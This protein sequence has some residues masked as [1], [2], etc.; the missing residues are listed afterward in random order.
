MTAILRSLH[1]ALLVSDL[2]KAE[3]F[4]GQVLGLEQAPRSLNFPGLW[5][6]VGDF[7]LHLIHHAGWQAP[8]PRPD[9]W[10]RNAHIALQV[11]DLAVIKTQLTE[12]GY[13]L[14]MSSS[15]RAALFTQDADGNVVELSQA[16]LPKSS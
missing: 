5:Y 15:G 1:V 8:C 6:Q 10:G 2:K 11:N 13:P 4:Y 12:Q 7:Q 16:Q 9:K 3:T 14:Q